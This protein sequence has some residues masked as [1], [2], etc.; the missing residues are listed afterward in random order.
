MKNRYMTIML[1]ALLIALMPACTSTEKIKTLIVTGQSGDV[2]LTNSSQ[3]V[4]QILD[5]TGLFATKLLIAPPSGGDMAGFSPDFSKYKLVIVDYEGDAWPEKTS[6]ALMDFVNNGGGAVFL[7]SESDP[8][9]PVPE[10]VSVSKKHDFE[11]RNRLSNHPVTKGLPER[12][13]HP[14]DVIIQGVKTA[15]E[16]I[17]VLASAFSVTSFDGSGVAEAVL[18]AKKYGKGR[19]FIDMLGTPDNEENKALHC[20]GY[21]VTLQ[22]GAEWAA[23][24]AVTQEVPFDFPTAAGPVLRPDFTGVDFDKAFKNMGSYEIGKSTLYFTW[25][26]NEIRKASGDQV[27]LLNLEKKMVEVLK[28]STS[29]IDAK[30]LILKELSWMGTEYSVPTIKELGSVPELKDAVDFALTRL[31]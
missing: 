11:V 15:G 29:T 25:L 23:T 7:R 31:Q 14:E 28:N 8:G 24:G 18:L 12:W 21:I 2:N 26:Q 19:I 1:S 30:K 5:E 3:A 10:T 6:S 22:R 9:T 27:A 16:D 13:L 20:A 4:Q 17:Q